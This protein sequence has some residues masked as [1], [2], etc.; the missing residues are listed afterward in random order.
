MKWKFVL[1]ASFLWAGIATAEQVTTYDIAHINHRGSNM[2]LVV[3]SDNFFEQSENTQARWY[4]AL[5]VCVRE[6]NL[7]GQTIVVADVDDHLRFYG[8]KSWHKFLRTLD[9]DWVRARVNKEL[10][11][12]Y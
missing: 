3:T 10:T 5:K 12:Y 4:T 9:M 6:A 7:A 8:P 1:I 2:I 11:C